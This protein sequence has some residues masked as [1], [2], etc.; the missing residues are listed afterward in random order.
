MYVSGSEAGAIYIA[1]SAKFFRCVFLSGRKHSRSI[2]YRPIYS[3]PKI[4][5]ADS[6][7]LWHQI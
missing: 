4:F 3:R 7:P 5:T 1:H 6:V 2:V